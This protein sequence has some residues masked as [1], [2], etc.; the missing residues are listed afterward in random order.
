[1][2]DL[3]R[4]CLWVLEYSIQHWLVTNGTVQLT[5]STYLHRYLGSHAQLLLRRKVGLTRLLTAASSFPLNST[6]QNDGE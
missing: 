4:S 5:C 3:H 1:M 6:L 2:L